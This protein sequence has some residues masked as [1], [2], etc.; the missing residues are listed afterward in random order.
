MDDVKTVALE[1]NPLISTITI[2]SEKIPGNGAPC[3]IVVTPA[4]G[5]DSKKLWDVMK[6]AVAELNRSSDRDAT[7]YFETKEAA[8]TSVPAITRHGLAHDGL[9]HN[10]AG[11]ESASIDTISQDNL[12]S[13]TAKMVRFLS[14]KL[15]VISAEESANIHK[16]LGISM[17]NASKYKAN[18]NT[19]MHL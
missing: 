11:G 4:D 15:N 9:N 13:V 6:E 5:A 3:S 8:N 1:N 14:N 2:K 17:N 10:L 12:P 7:S 18:K 16:E 19:Q